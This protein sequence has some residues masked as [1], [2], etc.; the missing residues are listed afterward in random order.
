MRRV[1]RIT[2]GTRLDEDVALGTGLRQIEELRMHL[3]NPG[4]VPAELFTITLD[5]GAGAEYDTVLFSQDMNGVQDL[6]WLPTRPILLFP[7]DVLALLWANAADDTYG[8][9]IVWSGLGA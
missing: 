3:E 6:H 1:T 8:V 4:A 2:G 9:E 7:G 5:S